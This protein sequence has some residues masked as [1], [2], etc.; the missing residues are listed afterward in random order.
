MAKGTGEKYH[1]TTRELRELN[2]DTRPALNRKGGTVMVENP[3]GKPYRFVLDGTGLTVYVGPKGGF[4]ELRTRIGKKAVRISLGEVNLLTVK[5]A[6]LLAQE[7][8]IHIRQTGED[9]RERTRLVAATRL[10]KSATVGDAMRGYIEHLTSLKGRGKVKSAGVDGARDS[11][12]RLERPEVGL[13]SQEIAQ[14]TDKEVT[15]G[16]NRLRH[17]AMLRSNRLPEAARTKLKRHG[18]WWELERG[19][20]VTKLGLTG[21]TV[22]LAYA[23][24][25]AAAEH[26]MSDARRGVERVLA[27]ERKNATR[28]NRTP[29]LFH[30]PFD[31]LIETKLFRSTRDLRKHY[32]AARVRNPLGVDD[33]QT[34]QKSL[35]NVLKSLLARRDMKSGANSTAI[36]YCLLMLLWG[37]RRNEGARLRWYDSCSKDELDLQLASWAWL[38]PRP[39]V[40]NP[41]TGLRGSQVFLHDTKS[42]EFQLLPVA[43]F[44]EKVL[45]WR[46]AARK[47]VEQLLERQVERGKKQAAKVRE[48]TIDYIKRAKAVALHERAQW[49][50]DNARRWV[51]PARNPKAKDGY[52]SDSKSLLTTVREDAGLLNLAKEIDIGLTPHDFR[53]TMGRFAA[54]LLPGN[55]VSQLLHHHKPDDGSGMAK[56]S[57]RYS[58]QEWPELREAME[59]VD[60]AI[61]RT[62]PRAWNILKGSDRQLLDE[63]DDP[64]LKVPLY[65]ARPSG[66]KKTTRK[67]RGDH[68]AA[69]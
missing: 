23:A 54:K 35:P 48:Q 64:E 27:A 33:T 58:E 26:T 3:G 24:G 15:D 65:R 53:R 21:K 61:V 25:L 55:V 30:N 9:P 67:R 1:L 14:L 34:G 2:V 5:D 17:S 43:Y 40:R 22:E 59:K 36:D 19:E 45:R 56:V 57:E 49:R 51:F 47:E 12:A 11:L 7:H 32:E 46:A 44:A 68:R 69:A 41:T 38:A 42:G 16:W 52:Y 60:E 20:L 6:Q 66:S 13:A 50:L 8:K 63:R 28:E 39:D 29:V 10:A 31:V 4:Y 18:P 37:T 62:S